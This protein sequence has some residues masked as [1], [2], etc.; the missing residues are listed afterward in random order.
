[1]NKTMGWAAALCA[2]TGPGWAAAAG[3]GDKVRIGFVTDMTGLYSDF[4]GP[5]GLDAVRMAIEDFGG[6]VLGKEIEVLSA[7][8]QNKADIAASKA[9]QWWD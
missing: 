6:K 4:D 7:D 8:H 1:M 5:G 3:A 9:R 2:A